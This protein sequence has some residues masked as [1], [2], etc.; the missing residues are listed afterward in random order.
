MMESEQCSVIK[1][2]TVRMVRHLA[3]NSMTFGGEAA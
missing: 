2:G 3:V 1:V